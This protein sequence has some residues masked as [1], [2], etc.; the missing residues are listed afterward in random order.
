MI[1]YTWVVS[2]RTT[3]NKLM[4]KMTAHIEWMR[5]AC[6]NTSIN[7]S[8]TEKTLN[9]VWIQKLYEFWIPINLNFYRKNIWNFF[10]L[11]NV[12]IFLKN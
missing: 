11:T 12:F 8:I 4:N 3:P 6:L 2:E 7:Y 1:N 5:L 9:Y 10:Y